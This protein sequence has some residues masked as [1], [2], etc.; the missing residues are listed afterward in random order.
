LLVGLRVSLLTPVGGIPGGSLV[1]LLA[2]FPVSFLTTSDGLC[3]SSFIRLLVG[4][5]VTL[6]P[7]VDGFPSSSLDGLLNG[8][9][10][11]LRFTFLTPS[12]G[13]GG[14][15]LVG[16]LV[17]LRLF[18]YT[19]RQLLRGL[20]NPITRQITRQIGHPLVR[21]FSH[22]FRL[23]LVLLPFDA[24]QF[25]SVAFPAIGSLSSSNRVGLHIGFFVE[26]LAELLIL[27][28]TLVDDI[29]GGSLVGLLDGS[30]SLF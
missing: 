10:V 1:G 13:F 30:R 26:F 18:S 29:R 28:H 17:G 3:S 20:A 23:A 11:R 21:E 16:L 7:P 4:L 2:G 9:L 6:L 19:R 24:S 12:V 22:S 8:L 14:G 27:F 25:L 15:S 5:R